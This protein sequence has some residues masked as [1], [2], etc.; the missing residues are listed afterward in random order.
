M[1][2]FLL[3]FFVLELLPII[4]FQTISQSSL[5]IIFTQLLHSLTL[6]LTLFILLLAVVWV[7]NDWVTLP[8]FDLRMFRVG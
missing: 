1:R 5:H 8:P 6:Y 4:I 3:L 2:C 7:L